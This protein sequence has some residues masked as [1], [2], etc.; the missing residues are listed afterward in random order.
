MAS[1]RGAVFAFLVPEP[2]LGHFGTI[3]NKTKVKSLKLPL[4]FHAH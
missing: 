4:A 3:F 2:K 1:G